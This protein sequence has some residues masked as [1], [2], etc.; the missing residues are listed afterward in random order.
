MKIVIT[1]SSSQQKR[2]PDAGDSRKTEW[3]AWSDGGDAGGNPEPHAVKRS[4]AA[5]AFGGFLL[6]ATV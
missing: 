1:N 2:I 5:P 3:L 6:L 4:A